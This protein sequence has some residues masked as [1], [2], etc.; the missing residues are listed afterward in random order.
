LFGFSLIFAW[1]SLFLSL[2]FPDSIENPGNPYKKSVFY[3]L[4]FT[5]FIIGLPG[6]LFGFRCFVWISPVLNFLGRQS[7]QKMFLF[8]FP[9]FLFGFH[10]T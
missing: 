10:F 6:F 8:G 9:G 5:D 7:K 2:D 3:C 4:D 1:I